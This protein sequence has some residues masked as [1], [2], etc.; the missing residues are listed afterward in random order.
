MLTMGQK[1]AVTKELQDR[2]RKCS[3][4]EKTSMLNEFT[5]LTGYNRC[6]ASQ[7]LSKSNILGYVQIA[8]E[9]IKYVPDH[10][11]PVEKRRN[12]MTSMFSLP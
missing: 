4:K 9:K 10:K 11:N 2:Y 3:R 6:Y 7:I 5:R 12:T 1:K 8:G